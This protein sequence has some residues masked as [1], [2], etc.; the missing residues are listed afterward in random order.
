[1]LSITVKGIA[2]YEAGQW[3]KDWLY[4]RKNKDRSHIEKLIMQN[5]IKL[6]QELN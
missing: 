5:V 2:F 1:M 6:Y 3:E 4:M